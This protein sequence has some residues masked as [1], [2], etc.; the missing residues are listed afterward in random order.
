MTTSDNRAQP[1][2]KYAAQEIGYVLL[3]FWIFGGAVFFYLRFT[4]IFYQDNRAAIDG[5]AEAIWSAIGLGG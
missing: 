4:T 3:G 5:V 2:W 1:L